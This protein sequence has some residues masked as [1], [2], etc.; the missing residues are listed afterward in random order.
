MAVL[1]HLRTRDDLSTRLR[2]AGRGKKNEVKF[3]DSID[4]GRVL[5]V[6]STYFILGATQH[7]IAHSCISPLEAVQLIEIT[8]K[9]VRLFPTYYMWRCR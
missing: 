6:K 1:C 3:S 5:F 4:T 7:K 8:V 2:A 9:S